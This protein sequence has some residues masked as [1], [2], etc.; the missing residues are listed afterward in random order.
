MRK[1]IVSLLLAVCLVC[2][3]M[4]TV[5]PVAYAEEVK[6][7]C[8]NDLSY[9]LDLN[10]GHLRVLLVQPESPLVFIRKKH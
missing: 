2:G 10:T 6:G 4:G 5:G 1:R 7:L 9:T 8:G 3:L